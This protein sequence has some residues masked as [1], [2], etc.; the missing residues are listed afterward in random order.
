MTPHRLYL[1][2]P[3]S[4]LPD[5]NHHAFHAAA[6]ELRAAGYTVINPAENGLPPES[7]WVD[8]MRRD[9]SLMVNG[10]TA[11][12]TLPDAR[13][14]KGAMIEVN[15]AANLGMPIMA[16]HEWLAQVGA[17]TPHTTHAA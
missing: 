9:I 5:H 3:M 10:A 1:A 6:A 13:H 4:G 7:P 8:H 11:L 15:L 17:T 16:V 14:S 2:G 12:A